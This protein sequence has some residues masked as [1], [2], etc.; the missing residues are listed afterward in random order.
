MSRKIYITQNDK[1]KLQKLIDDIIMDNIKNKEHVKDLNAELNRAEIVHA[2]QIPHNVITMHSRV[3][4]FLDG[5]EEEISLVYPHE[6]D[7]TNNMISILSPV[8]TAIIGYHEGDTLEW[9]VPSGTTVVEV[10]R[11]LYQPEAAGVYE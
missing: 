4:L 6:A 7:V 2:A 8:G 5:S 9:S 3:L 10:K 1:Q 11:V